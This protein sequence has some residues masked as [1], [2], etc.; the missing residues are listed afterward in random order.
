[1]I[2]LSREDYQHVTVNNMEKKC[3]CP[4]GSR[5]KALERLLLGEENVK[6]NWGDMIKEPVAVMED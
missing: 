6:R 1:M 4:G 5:I 2:D 3:D